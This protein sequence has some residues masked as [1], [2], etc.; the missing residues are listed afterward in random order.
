MD[1]RHFDEDH[2]P[3]TIRLVDVAG[4][5]SSQHDA[6]HK[7]IVLIPRP[8]SDPEDPLN[9]S[10]NRKILAVSMAYLYVLGTG[11]ATSVQYSV[12]ADI[13]AD[14]GISTASLVQGTGLMFLFF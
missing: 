5:A 13:T 3:G 10:W 2:V 8:S 14:T 6:S 11:I 1:H 12:L 7:D 9:W 4:N